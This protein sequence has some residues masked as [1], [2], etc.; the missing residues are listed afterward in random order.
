MVKRLCIVWRTRG[1]AI[2]WTPCI[3]TS[4]FGWIWKLQI[5]HCKRQSSVTPHWFLHPTCLPLGLVV[6]YYP[7]KLFPLITQVKWIINVVCVYKK[8][9]PSLQLAQGDLGHLEFRYLPLPLWLTQKKFNQTT[10]CTN[11]SFVQCLQRGRA[12]FYST[13][14]N[15]TS[16]TIVG[17][18]AERFNLCIS[19][20]LCKL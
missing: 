15:E 5:T 20:I 10:S 16:K 4:P 18:W 9:V 19:S 12:I 8:Y 6:L 3:P 2:P 1:P 14:N 7:E 17:R 13:P 11:F